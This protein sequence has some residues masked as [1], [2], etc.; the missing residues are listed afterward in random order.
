VPKFLLDENVSPRI[1]KHLTLV[2]GLDVLAFPKVA[3][4]GT[5]DPDVR[6]LAGR[7]G[8][9][10][11]TLDSDFSALAELFR[12][13]PPGII[14]LHPPVVMRTLGGEKQMLDRFFERDAP[15]IDL[16]NSIVE[17]SELASQVLY[18]KSR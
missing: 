8:R 15:N 10:L 11:I 13:P 9:V 2:H 1:A 17:V 14:W 12:P 3:R 18:P 4:F 6:D 16:E 5:P 7:L